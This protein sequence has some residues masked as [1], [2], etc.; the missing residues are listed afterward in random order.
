[1][2]KD[3]GKAFVMIGCFALVLVGAFLLFGW[4]G[5]FGG[6]GESVK[7]QAFVEATPTP[8]ANARQQSPAHAGECR[9]ARLIER[10]GA[11]GAKI[12]ERK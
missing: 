8:K 5:L 12:P 6:S 10:D 9:L 1:M 2:D 3:Q 11:H 7:C 4:R